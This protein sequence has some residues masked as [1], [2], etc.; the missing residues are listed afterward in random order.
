VSAP[1]GSAS[2]NTWQ[3]QAG[4]RVYPL[5]SS[6]P[7]RPFIDLGLAVSWFQIDA[8]RAESPLLASSER[9]LTA[10]VF[11]GAGINWRLSSHFALLSGAGVSAAAAKP[12]VQFAGRD[13]LTLARPLLFWTLGVEYRATSEASRDW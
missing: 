7:I 3:A 6:G 12:V 5:S 4:P 9:L 13:V 11:A 8:T 1:E 10:G 2:I